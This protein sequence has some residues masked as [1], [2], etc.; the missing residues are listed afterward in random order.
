M[1]KEYLKNQA[2][3]LNSS[4]KKRTNENSRYKTFANLTI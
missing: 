2:Y 3:K 1:T 4:N